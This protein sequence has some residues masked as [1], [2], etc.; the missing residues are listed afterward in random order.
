MQR[1]GG[2]VAMVTGAASGI[3]RATALRLAAEGAN[4]FITDI[5]AE[6][7]EQTAATIREGGQKA[8]CHVFDVAEPEQ[9]GAAV[10]KVVAELG[11]LDVLCNIAGIHFARHLADVTA[12]D[13]RRMTSINLDGVFF[14]CQAAMPH[15]VESKGNIVNMASSAGLVGQI[16][17][18]PYCATKAGVVMLSKALAMEFA[19]A[20]VRVNSVCPGAVKTAITD[21]FAMPDNPDM[22][23]FSRLFSLNGEMCE[24]EQIADAVAFLA[25][26]DSSFINGIALPVDGG[27]TTG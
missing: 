9:C 7:L 14:L 8:I 4:L 6:A 17:N 27:Q 21:G 24:A 26:E 12:D 11:R 15:L 1:F 22:N 2:K 19:T 16:Y 13:W 25:A 10:D 3:G 18:A 5:T 20:G 23:L